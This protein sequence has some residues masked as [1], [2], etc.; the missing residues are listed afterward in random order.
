MEHLQFACNAVLPTFALI[1]LGVGLK[2]IGILQDALI[3]QGNTLCF[4]VLFPVLVFLNL[5]TTEKSILFKIDPD[6]TGYHRG[7]PVAFAMGRSSCSA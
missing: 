3:R 7:E 1:L 6:R 5:Y 4:Q 2:K